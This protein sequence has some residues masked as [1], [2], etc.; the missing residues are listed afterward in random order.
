[1]LRPRAEPSLTETVALGLLQGPAE[2]LPISSSAHVELLPW[3]LG[4]EHARLPAE[5][6][7]EVEVAL[8]AGTAV[9]LLAVRGRS[10]LRRPGLLGLAVLPAAAAGWRSRV[11]SSGGWERR[12]AIAAG[13]LLGS[14]ALV[15]ADRAPEG[16]RRA[17]RAR[18]TRCGSGSPRRPR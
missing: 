13:L 2:L 6:R 3:L 15:V 1:M 9:A 16:A 8:H 10:A 18:P 17:R 4:W 11:R 14:V 12:D 5:R 7:K